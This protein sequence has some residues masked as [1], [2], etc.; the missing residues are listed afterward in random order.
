MGHPVVV[1]R[2][3]RQ[4]HA[5]TKGRAHG[6][7]YF[8][9]YTRTEFIAGA[10]SV[11][12]PLSRVVRWQEDGGRKVLLPDDAVAVTHGAVAVGQVGRRGAL[13]P[14]TSGQGRG[15]AEDRVAP[16]GQGVRRRAQA[17]HLRGGLLLASPVLHLPRVPPPGGAVVGA[18][19]DAHLVIIIHLSQGTVIFFR[20]CKAT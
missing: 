11:V 13:P 6:P 18:R 3:Y 7:Y 1:V 14:A 16:D 4:R 2:T 8:L 10:L 9:Y 15:R 19:A 17:P 20:S 5:H 12:A